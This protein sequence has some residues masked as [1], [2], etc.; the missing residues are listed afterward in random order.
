ML[1]NKIKNVKS[2]G[3][4]FT[5]VEIDDGGVTSGNPF[6]PS[7]SRQVAPVS[8]NADEMKRA[9]VLCAYDAKDHTELTLAANEV[10]LIT[11]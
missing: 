9:R 2:L 4:P 11:S 10:R 3:G 6:A 8:V 7:N 1:T 5:A